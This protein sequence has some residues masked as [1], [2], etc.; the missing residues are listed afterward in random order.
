LYLDIFLIVFI[1]IGALGIATGESVVG[2][3]LI[4]LKNAIFSSSSQNNFLNN[5]NFFFYRFKKFSKSIKK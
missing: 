3:S 4:I 2:L 5:K 1:G